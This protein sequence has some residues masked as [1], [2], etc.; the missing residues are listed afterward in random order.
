MK[1]GSNDYK[2]KTVGYKYIEQTF[3]VNPDNKDD[4]MFISQR[5]LR[6]E[7]I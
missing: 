6:R 1:F 3:D 7:F 5:E 2:I 4:M